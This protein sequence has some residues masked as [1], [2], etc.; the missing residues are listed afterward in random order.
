MC[1]VVNVPSNATVLEHDPLDIC[2][3]NLCCTAPSCLRASTLCAAACVLRMSSQSC[4][5]GCFGVRDS[6]VGEVVLRLDNVSPA[7]QK[8]VNL[9]FAGFFSRKTGKNRLKP[10]KPVKNWKHGNVSLFPRKPF[11]NRSVKTAQTVNTS[12]LPF[13]AFPRSGPERSGN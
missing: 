7:H 10:V 11:Q 6:R 13:A 9:V 12:C 3:E 8:I 4:Q 1:R 2:V 5:S